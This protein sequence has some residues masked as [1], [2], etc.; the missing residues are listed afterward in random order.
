VWVVGFA[1]HGL[2]LLLAPSSAAPALAFMGHERH[3]T[4][5]ALPLI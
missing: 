1:A 4:R 5:G 2:G 3:M